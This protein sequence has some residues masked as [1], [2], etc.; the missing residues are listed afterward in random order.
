MRKRNFPLSR[1]YRLLESGPV[2]MVTTAY[3]GKANV[4]S[5]SWHMMMEFEPPLIGC[6]ISNRNYTFD[7]LK[8]TKECVISI[9]TAAL[10][11]KVVDCGSTSGRTVDKFK[12]FGL[13]A[14]RA[15]RV[16]APLIDECFA[17]LE[18]LVIDTKMI[19]KY[20]LFILKVVKAWINPAIRSPKTIH[21]VGRGE[22]RV[23]GRTI[24]FHTN[25][26]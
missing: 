16:K 21:H 10:A 9:P 14:K 19:K 4:M 15:F 17:N 3:K 1:V 11:K 22:F 13:T 24:R 8:N 7:I 20:N 12:A 23:D 2:V 26:I 25:V 5:M 18:C 6:I